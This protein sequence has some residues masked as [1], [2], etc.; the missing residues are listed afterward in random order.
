MYRPFSGRRLLVI[1]VGVSLFVVTGCSNSDSRSPS[2]SSTTGGGQSSHAAMPAW[3]VVHRYKCDGALTTAMNLP[4]AVAAWQPLD[5]CRALVAT[6]NQLLVDSPEGIQTLTSLHGFS[7]IEAVAKVRDHIWVIGSD[8]TGRPKATTVTS[9]GHADVVLPHQIGSLAAAAGYKEGVLLATTSSGRGA[10]TYVTAHDSAAVRRL[11][12]EPIRVA[13][14]GASIAVS[15]QT[16]AGSQIE[17]KPARGVWRS[18]ELGA[19]VDV[20]QIALASDYVV[21]AV[22]ENDATGAPV[23]A[24]LVSAFGTRA[25]WRE[26]TFSGA[27]YVGSVATDGQIVYAS[28]PRAAETNRVLARNATRQGAWAEV[29]NMPASQSTIDLAS[30]GTR[31][32]ARGDTLVAV[33]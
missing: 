18:K 20:R 12:G 22:N 5:D 27:T 6:K 30:T 11:R 13:V 19:G 31:V 9:T 28:V 14:A 29:G 16:K 7:S 23:R 21:V 24:R 8:P 25:P 32:W 10:L 15:T 17:W 4:P 26:T 1:C 33:R 3:E 2:A